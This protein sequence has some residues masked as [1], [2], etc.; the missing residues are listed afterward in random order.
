MTGESWD[1]SVLRALQ[2]RAAVE[3]PGTARNAGLLRFH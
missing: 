1:T 2:C 3:V